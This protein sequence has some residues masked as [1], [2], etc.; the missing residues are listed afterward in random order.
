MI[1][2]RVDF[3][4]DKKE[5]R[6]LKEQVLVFM[7]H[8]ERKTKESADADVFLGG[9]FAKETIAQAEE[10]DADIFVRFDWKYEDISDLLENILK[11]V[12]KDL[13]LE[14][15]K[16]HGS[17]DYFRIKGKGKLTFEVI[18][19]TRI[20]RVQEA[21]NVTDLSY[22]H[23]N[24]VKKN[25]NGKMKRELALA[26]RFFKA[27]GAYGAES[28]I[29][30]FSGYGLECLIIH[31]K[32]FERMIK[33]LVKVGLG[34]RLI[35]D[36]KKYYKKKSD[37]LFELNESKLN[38]PIILI[39]PTWKERNVLASLSR[40]TFEKFQKAARDFL[41]RPSESF[42]YREKPEKKL[43][44]KKRDGE[45][46]K[47]TLKT[48]RQEGDIAGTK[49]K[50]FSFLL[51]RMLE[52][53]F[54][55]KEENFEYVGE[56]QMA[57]YYIVLE[58]KK[59]ILRIGPPITKKKEISKFKLKNRKAFIK[60]GIVY[61]KEKISFSAEEFL[62]KWKKSREGRLKMEDMAITELSVN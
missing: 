33:E 55:I 9:S 13:G 52:K 38:S 21:R 20:K 6:E 41:K 60:D 4:I 51:R 40:E 57:E 50:K 53:Y 54:I 14:M 56:G 44:F 26:K 34:D 2:K 19:V 45:M 22:F 10:Y 62:E 25:L 23:V 7:K 48:N 28:Y 49:M 58:K 12:T 24:Y 35:I 29:H 61:S 18:P 43:T 30:G 59:E 42:F 5:F 27:Q 1:L 32:T 3:S 31:Y 17:R 8:L 39:D 36:I 11:R 37:V 47:I 46:L 15:K 16:M